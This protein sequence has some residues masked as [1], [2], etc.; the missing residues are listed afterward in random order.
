MHEALMEAR[1]DRRRHGIFFL[2][3]QLLAPFVDGRS[4]IAELPAFYDYAGDDCA[5]RWSTYLGGPSRPSCMFDRLSDALG[6]T[7]DEIETARCHLESGEWTLAQ[8]AQQ[9]DED[10]LGAIAAPASL[11]ICSI[12]IGPLRR[13]QMGGLALCAP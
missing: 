2:L 12:V 5:R 10:L 6:V 9:L 3:L 1:K 11:Q 7:A 13:L 4:I 8:V